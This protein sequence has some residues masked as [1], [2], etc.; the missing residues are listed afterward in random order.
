MK[1]TVNN[2]EKQQEKPFPKLMVD[3]DNVVYYFV[4][5]GYG[6]PIANWDETKWTDFKDMDASEWADLNLT[7]FNGSIT[8]SND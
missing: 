4:R 6:L 1:V 2:T 7:D 8:L 5:K 3:T